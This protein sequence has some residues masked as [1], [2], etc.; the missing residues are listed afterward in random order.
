MKANSILLR[1]L[2]A[3][4][5]FQAGARAGTSDVLTD[6]LF[7]VNG[8]VTE[9]SVS[10]PGLNSSG[11]NT[12]TGEGTLVLTYSPGVAGSYFFDAWFDNDLSVPFFNE[13]GAVS[14]TPA[15]GQSWQIGDPTA[16]YDGGLS[17]GGL[18]PGVDIADNAAL[19]VLS[20]SNDLPGNSSNYN[21]PCTPSPGSSC[22]GDASMAMGFA[23][24][25][26]AG[27]FETI[28]LNLSETAPDGG[29]YLQQIHPVDPNNDSQLN[30]Y[31]TGSAV[32]GS[33]VPPPPTPE[34]STLDSGFLGDRRFRIVAFEGI[35]ADADEGDASPARGRRLFCGAS[36][37]AAD[38]AA[39]GP[40]ADYGQDRALGA[41]DSGHSA[42]DL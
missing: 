19:N 13:Y 22:N 6:Y 9:Y 24:T 8:T 4:G 5:V 25:V 15:A 35:L 7:N 33:G 39:D 30:L 21:P 29:F 42:H 41:C 34:P 16:Y 38:R 36:G 40:G 17:P 11:F 31:F 3:L 27:Q 1:L 37:R 14:G 10:V 32:T 28:T 26:A 18:G 23:F 12:T 2:L 20:N